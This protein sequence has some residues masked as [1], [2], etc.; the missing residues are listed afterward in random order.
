ML[1]NSLTKHLAATV[2]AGIVF[3]LA[4][5]LVAPGLV[6]LYLAREHEELLSRL[7]LPGAAQLEVLGYDRG[8]FSSRLRMRLSLGLCESPSCGLVLN[9]VIYHGPIALN[10]PDTAGEGFVRAV[11]ETRSISPRCLVTCVCS[12]RHPPLWS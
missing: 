9:S 8:W 6:G 3:L 2:I 10:A 4:V 12:Q 7:D 11:V 1:R 5:A